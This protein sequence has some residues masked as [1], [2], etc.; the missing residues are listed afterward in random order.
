M[1]RIVTIFS[2]AAFFFT[3]GFC[4]DVNNKESTD[5]YAD[6]GADIVSSYLWRGLMLDPTPNMQGWGEFGIGS[7]TIGAWASSNFTGT[8]L[9]T[10]LY[11]SY[12]FGPVDIVFT[13]YYV[14]WENY[15]KFKKE[16]TIHAGEIMLEY[17][18]SEDFPLQL[19]L[20][21]I[22]YGADAKVSG[23]TSKNNFSTYFE[24]QY[25]FAVG[26]TEIS[27]IAGGVTHESGFYESDG[28]AII[29]LGAMISKEIKISD[30]FSLPVYFSVVVN[31]HLESV[32]TVFGI[33]F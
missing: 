15:F 2:L 22:I 5:T 9:E 8:F 18:I 4:Q 16:E 27:L 24:L 21:T 14:G 23:D 7:L 19:S 28:A 29:N 10:D 11:A 20:G 30:A 17:T 1:K 33:S 26:E 32:Y 3:S 13:D 12:N 31:P 25:P 6:L